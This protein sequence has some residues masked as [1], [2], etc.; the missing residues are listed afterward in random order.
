[1]KNGK[2]LIG[3]GIVY[4]DKPTCAISTYPFNYRKL[5]FITEA[6]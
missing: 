6:V 1:M 2:V 5:H 3:D 4:N